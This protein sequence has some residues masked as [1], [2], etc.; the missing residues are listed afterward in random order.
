MSTKLL[1]ITA[2]LKKPFCCG[3]EITTGKVTQAAP[4]VR[5]WALGLTEEEFLKRCR[6]KAWIIEEIPLQ[7]Q[8]EKG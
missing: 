5:S 6:L 7:G 2:G 8:Q 4:I 1:R 3:V